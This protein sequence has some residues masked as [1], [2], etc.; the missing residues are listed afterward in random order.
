MAGASETGRV[1]FRK[2]P[3]LVAQAAAAMLEPLALMAAVRDESGAI[4]DFEWRF[5]NSAGL[6]NAPSE[7]Q[8]LTGQRLTEVFPV[9]GPT[10]V[11]R[12]R[13]V[14]ETGQPFLAEEFSF[15]DSLSGDGTS[16]HM[17]CLRASRSGDGVAVTW[18]DAVSPDADRLAHETSRQLALYRQIIDVAG[19]GIWVVDAD[20]RTTYINDALCGL[21]DKP[22]SAIIGLRRSELIAQQDRDAYV[23]PTAVRRD[24]TEQ[25]VHLKTPAG[26]SRWGRFAISALV[27]SDG[28]YLGNFAL[29]TDI[30]DEV[31]A[32]DRQ[33]QAESRFEE[34]T[35]NAPI[36]QALVGLDGTFIAVNPAYCAMTGYSRDELIGRTFQSI[37]APSDVDV[38][39]HQAAELAAG[40][41]PSYSMDKRYISKSGG[42]VWVK[43]FVSVVRD[44]DGRPT[45]FIA[46][47]IDIDLQKRAERTAARALRGLEYRSTHDPL[48][49]LPNRAE[50]V[51]SLKEALL[52]SRSRN[53]TAVF[54]VD[55][56]HF[57]QVNDGISHLAGDAVLTE[58][59]KRIKHCV[60]PTD[61]VSRLGGD[62]FAV[63]TTDH[64]SIGELKIVAERIRSAIANA[65]FDTVAAHLHISVSIG[66]AEAH[67]GSTPQTLLSEADLALY[68]AKEQGRNR[69]VVADREMLHAARNR[70]ALLD[71]LHAGIASDEFHAWFQPVV[72]LQSRAV[73]GY[74]AL[75]RWSTEE[76]VR[77]AAD[78]IEVAE[79]SG[80]IHSIGASVIS[81]SIDQLPNLAPDQLLS[82]NASPHQ[83]QVPTFGR[84]VLTALD[85]ANANPRQLIVEITEQALLQSGTASDSNIAMLHRAGVKLYVDDFGVGYS[86]LAILRDYPI[87]G[88]KLDRSFSIDPD[89]RSNPRFKLVSGISHLASHLGLQRVAEG[90]ETEEQLDYLVETGWTTGQGY[91]F[92]KA[93]PSP[94]IQVPSARAART[95]TVRA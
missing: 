46:Q 58:I 53:Q 54:F 81:E 66:I 17:I 21:L 94:N 12:Y 38:D 61:L 40:R 95:S 15:A 22:S 11:E 16:P 44:A 25:D 35:D 14:V 20:G 3:E 28:E 50:C 33:R 26:H 27:D 42:E 47:A 78:F 51:R 36:G 71:R 10:L 19:V 85:R 30:T 49:E 60:G 72:D 75:A 18:N 8:G 62:E 55:V 91:L 5:I 84:R 43:L 41:I 37:T 6:R 31:Q 29:V 67:E 86:S 82:V 69:W 7:A 23:E 32:V 88:I 24:T 1:P 79:D 48:T 73:V 92:G 13:E 57:K 59:G 80:L 68:Q 90:I 65:A 87:D 56:D 9:Q 77:S 93:A 45:H 83:L 63:V 74:E 64:D 76:G 4:I 34:A 70:L 89:A 52:D 39:A 2:I